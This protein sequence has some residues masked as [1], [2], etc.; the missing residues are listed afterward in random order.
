ML[1][2]VQVFVFSG[3]SLILLFLLE[4][5]W[6]TFRTEGALFFVLTSP[7]FLF[8]WFLNCAL[9]FLCPFA[10]FNFLYAGNESYDADRIDIMITLLISP[11]LSAIFSSMFIPLMIPEAV[12]KGYFRVL[13]SSH[14]I[15]NCI[16]F[17]KRAAFLRHFV[18]GTS[19]ASFAVPFALLVLRRLGTLRGVEMALF[20]ATYIATLTL[21]SYPIAY[22]GFASQEN[23][24]QILKKM[25]TTSPFITRMLYRLKECIFI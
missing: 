2:G 18:I 22:I 5:V 3:A 10:L 13:E 8:N 20:N 4:Y 6:R 21:L 15:Q 7:F 14:E 19:L 9:S 17:R 1:S 12:T 11:W 25:D 24:S 23:L 16:P